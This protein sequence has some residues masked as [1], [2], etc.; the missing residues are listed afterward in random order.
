MPLAPSLTPP[1]AHRRSLASLLTP[2]RSPPPG[3]QPVWPL[4]QYPVS[5]RFLALSRTEGCY[6]SDSLGV[7]FGGGEASELGSIGV[8]GGYCWLTVSGSTWC[9]NLHNMKI[10]FLKALLVHSL[11]NAPYL[12]CPEGVKQP[13]RTVFFIGRVLLELWFSLL[14]MGVA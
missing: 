3:G 4:P 7:W 12:H 8:W 10:R 1:P 11:S 5:I 13:C 14:F 9:L 2:P 6:E